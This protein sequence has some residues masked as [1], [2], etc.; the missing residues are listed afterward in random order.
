MKYLYHDIKFDKNTPKLAGY[1]STLRKLTCE[2]VG[3]AGK[4][5]V[6]IKVRKSKYFPRAM[7]IRVLRTEVIDK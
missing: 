4:D 7:T 5:E 6:F 1:T 3:A 2:I